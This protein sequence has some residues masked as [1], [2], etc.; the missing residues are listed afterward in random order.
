MI[1]TIH[2]LVSYNLCLMCI[3]PVCALLHLL[4]CFLFYF[5]SNYFYFCFQ[6][7]FSIYNIHFINVLLGLLLFLV[8]YL[9][10]LFF[11]LFFFAFHTAILWNE[12]KFCAE[13]NMVL[14][15]LLDWITFSHYVLF[16]MIMAE[17]IIFFVLLMIP[18]GFFLIKCMQCY[19]AR[20]YTSSEIC[21]RTNVFLF[22]ILFRYIFVVIRIKKNVLS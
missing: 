2:P 13:W 19:V 15:N 7:S 8:F 12:M 10:L 3:F 22:S 9:F 1:I 16:D 4:Q 14:I 18:V 20:S 17:T 5:F 6:S 21:T 11:R